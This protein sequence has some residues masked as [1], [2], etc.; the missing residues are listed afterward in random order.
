MQ[1]SINLTYLYSKFEFKMDQK[2]NLTSK[3]IKTLKENIL[4]NS[5]RYWIFQWL[6]RHD[7]QRQAT[8]EKKKGMKF[9]KINNIY[10]SQTKKYRLMNEWKYFT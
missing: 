7:S 6:Y 5:L 2:P 9:V 3:N 4:E 10:I 8:E 1:K